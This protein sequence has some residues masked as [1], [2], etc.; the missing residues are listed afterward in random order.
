MAK[1]AGR[2]FGNASPAIGKRSALAETKDRRNCRRPD[3]PGRS[4]QLL[5]SILLDF[6]VDAGILV[7]MRFRKTPLLRLAIGLARHA[8]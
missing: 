8:R 1:K 4:R 5:E 2:R 6:D 3:D 7:K